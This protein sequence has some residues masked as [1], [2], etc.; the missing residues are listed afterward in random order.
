[1]TTPPDQETTTAE[2]LYNEAYQCL[3]TGD[4]PGFA[5][6]CAPKIVLN[7]SDASEISLETLQRRV[8]AWRQAFTGYDQAPTE[9]TRFPF[10]DGHEI[11]VFTKYLLIHTG[12][13]TLPGGTAIDATSRE[14]EVRVAT[15]IHVRGGLIA[16]LN[17]LLTPLA[18]SNR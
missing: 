17:I 12:P 13:F 5:A 15:F 3:A 6:L 10:R 7:L 1:M 8:E 18:S 9:Q 2:R 11:A 4:Y 16:R 14:I